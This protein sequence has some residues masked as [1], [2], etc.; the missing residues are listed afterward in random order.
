MQDLELCFDW[1]D[2]TDA[3]L[4]SLINSSSL[5]ILK[6]LC[7]AFWFDLPTNLSDDQI[8]VI[9]EPVVEEIAGNL[10]ELEVLHLPLVLRDNLDHRKLDRLPKLHCIRRELVTF[11]ATAR[12]VGKAAIVEDRRVTVVDGGK[13]RTTWAR[14]ELTRVRVG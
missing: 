13:R 1:L 14:K 12:R 11:E 3:K 9:F 10:K 7:T 8:K 6:S 5:R 4:L 2:V